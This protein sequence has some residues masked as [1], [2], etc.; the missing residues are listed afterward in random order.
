M[1]LGSL[2]CTANNYFRVAAGVPLGHVIR[3]PFGSEDVPLKRCLEYVDE[4]RAMFEDS[5][6]GLAKPAA[7]VLEPIQ[8]EGGVHVARAQWLKAISE[9]AEDL[10]ALV[11]YDDIQA[12]CGR[13]GRYFSFDEEIGR[14]SCRERVVLRGVGRLAM[15][16]SS[17]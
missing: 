9:L 5:S 14:A 15:K 8:A 3:Q 13:T 7:F 2:A 11:I 4:L 17:G 10:G 6:S 1:T 16:M 12:G